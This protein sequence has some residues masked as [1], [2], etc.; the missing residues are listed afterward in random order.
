VNRSLLRAIALT[1]AT[2]LATPPIAMVPARAQSNELPSLGE[3]GADDLSPANERKLGEQIMREVVADPL[4]LPDPDTT[5]YLNKLGYQLVSS[6]NARHMDFNFFCV[7]DPMIN[8]FAL[9]GGFIGVH[10]GL[11][12]L[13][14]TESE[15]AAVI[16]HEIGHVEQ[17]H[18]AR[19]LAKQR[20]SAAV[21]IGALLLALLAARS[22]SSSAGDLTQAAILGGQAA[23]IQQQ[24]NFSREAEREADRVGFNTLNGAGFDVSA[25]ATFF[26]RMQQS[27]RIYESA[28]PAYLRTHPLTTERISDM[29]NRLREV[30]SKQR[31]DSL[32]FQ[33]VRAR[34]RVLQD[35]ST[36]GLRDARSSFSGQLANRATPSEVASYYGLALANL[37]LGDNALAL[38]NALAARKRTGTGS[39]MI[40]KVYAQSRY[41]A[42]RTPQER[43]DAMQFARETTTRFPISR[44]I[45]LNYVDM[46]QLSNRHDEAIAYLRDQLAIPRSEP[47]YYELLARSY[48]S[49]NKRTLQHQATGELYALI[50]ATPAAIQ[51]FQL[52]RKA[53]D[54]DFYVLSEV[55]ARLRQLMQQMRERREDLIRAGKR[56]PPEDKGPEN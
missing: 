21:A 3:A 8:A 34:L 28:A 9:P 49:L 44:L 5:E 22:G 30:R 53:A 1:V 13:A 45:A 52:A 26:G 17:R 48:G 19:M 7:K 29:Q 37:K 12:L 47:K 51:Q 40:E 27:T 16:G 39:A 46:L 10:S 24:L 36:Q 2:T 18:I 54:A 38:E 25:M 6:S 31:A 41:M 4:Y 15:L 55:D 43:D 35:D 50:G 11:I 56:P 14:Q 20:E 23:A 42:A 33:L 32:D